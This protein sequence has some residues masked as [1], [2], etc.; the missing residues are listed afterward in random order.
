MF[1]HQNNNK[2]NHVDNVVVII[3]FI[4]FIFIFMSTAESMKYV[5]Y[6][7]VHLMMQYL[8]EMGV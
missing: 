3:Y 7:K 2:K 5:V 8:I 6:L 1:F 4:Y